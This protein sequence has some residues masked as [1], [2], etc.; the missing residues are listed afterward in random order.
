[1]THFT[2]GNSLLPF[3][4]LS[5]LLQYAKNSVQADFH[6]VLSSLF[7]NIAYF[8]IVSVLFLCY[9]SHFIYWLSASDRASKNARNLSMAVAS[10]SRLVA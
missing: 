10:S 1:M 9:R 6:P 5:T 3:Q 8:R 4:Q 7:G 2:R